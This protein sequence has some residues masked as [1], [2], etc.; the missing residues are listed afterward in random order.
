MEALDSVFRSVSVIKPTELLWN[1]GYGKSKH[2]V[3]VFT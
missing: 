1:K 2:L 3:K